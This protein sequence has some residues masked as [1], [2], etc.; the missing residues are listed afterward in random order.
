MDIVRQ[1]L[2]EERREAEK[3][4]SIEVVK[5]L[6]AD[7]DLG[8][9]MCSD[10]NELD[11]Q[12]LRYGIRFIFVLCRCMSVCTH[13]ELM[14]CTFA[15]FTFDRV[16]KEQYLSDLTRDNVQLIVNA[17]WERPTERVEE[18]I[19]AKL[20]AP[21]FVLPR[22]QK[23]PVPR[24]LTKWEQFAQEKGIKKAKK[25]KKVFDEELDVSK[26]YIIDHYLLWSLIFSTHMHYNK[27]S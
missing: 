26:T 3:Y 11:E 25:D 18:C 16:E 9:L 1:V 13:I 5:H 17:L 21:S 4:K 7:V 6:D 14:I 2:D 8:Y 23:C 24:P 10:G 12:Q 22:S 19:V 20:P 27:L 15:I